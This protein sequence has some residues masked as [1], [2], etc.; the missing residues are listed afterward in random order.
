MLPCTDLILYLLYRYGGYANEFTAVVGEHNREFN[1]NTEA[2]H[3]ISRVII[4]QAYDKFV[5]I[6]VLT[7]YTLEC[8]GD[9]INLLIPILTNCAI[10]FVRYVY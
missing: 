1:E 7:D 9:F 8:T 5:A 6:P 4:H 10:S 3:Q 2:V